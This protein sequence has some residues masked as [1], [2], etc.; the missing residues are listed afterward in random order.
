MRQTKF[1]VIATGYEY[2][3]M[4]LEKEKLGSIGADGVMILFPYC[5]NLSRF[6]VLNHFRFIAEK[7]NI[8]IIICDNP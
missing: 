8:P 2:P 6:Q 5:M 7:V 3:C 4:D 1:K